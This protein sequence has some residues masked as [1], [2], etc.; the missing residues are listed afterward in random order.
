[1]RRCV[2]E[3]DIVFAS[4]DGVFTDPKGHKGIVGKGFKQILLSTSHQEQSCYRKFVVRAEFVNRKPAPAKKNER[5]S[6]KHGRSRGGMKQAGGPRTP[7]NQAFVPT[8]VWRSPSSYPP[9]GGKRTL[10]S[11]A[12]SMSIVCL[13]LWNL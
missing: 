10:D 4:A 11:S 7:G 9:G 6:R 8:A 2:I 5:A 1:M 3:K 13:P 12:G